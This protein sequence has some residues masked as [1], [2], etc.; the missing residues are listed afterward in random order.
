MGRFPSI[1]LGR[2][3]ANGLSYGKGSDDP[4]QLLVSIEIKLKKGISKCPSELVTWLQIENS[5]LTLINYLMC[6]ARYS[7]LIKM[8]IYALNSVH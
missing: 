1:S 8:S 7:E 6:S 3:G 5:N 2:G 4:S